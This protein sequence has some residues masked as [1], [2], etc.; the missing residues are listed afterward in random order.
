MI[1]KLL[2]IFIPFLEK[3]KQATFLN[4]LF[5]LILPPNPPK[6]I[7]VPYSLNE[8]KPCFSSFYRKYRLILNSLPSI[9]FKKDFRKNNVSIF[10][11]YKKLPF[12]HSH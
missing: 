4:G 9:F 7:S 12:Q 1:I 3:N 8:N 6:R 2:F 10:N 11:S 5:F